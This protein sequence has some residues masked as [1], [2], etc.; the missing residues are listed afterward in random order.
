MLHFSFH[1]GVF[2]KVVFNL[3]NTEIFGYSHC[4][5]HFTPV[6]S[7]HFQYYYATYSPILMVLKC[8]IL[9]FTGWVKHGWMVEWDGIVFPH[10]VET[11]PGCYQRLS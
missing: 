8:E 2:G 3:V 6:T 9:L 7:L 1:S 4:E 5:I 11:D 10:C